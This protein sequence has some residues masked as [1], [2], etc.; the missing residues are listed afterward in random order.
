MPTQ[1]GHHPPLVT[2]APYCLLSLDIIYQLGK[3]VGDGSEAPCSKLSGV[4]AVQVAIE[5][6]PR[7]DDDQGAARAALRGY[8]ESGATRIEGVMMMIPEHSMR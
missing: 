7:R 5:E 6:E 3:V 4:G 1:P 8:V 2:N